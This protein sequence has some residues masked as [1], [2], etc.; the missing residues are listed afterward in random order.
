MARLSRTGNCVEPPFARARRRIIGIN[1]SANAIFTAGNSDEHQILDNQRS[2]REAVALG[3]LGGAYVPD[4]IAGL[5]VQR[6][7]MRVQRRHENFITEDGKSAVDSPATW[8]NV[9][10][11]QA[12]VLPDR[13]PGTRVQGIDAVVLPGTVHNSVHNKRRCFKFAPCHR[14]ICPLGYERCGIRRIDLIQRTE[15]MPRIVSG[16]HQPVLWLLGGVEQPLESHLPI[17]LRCAEAQR[18]CKRHNKRQC[19]SERSEESAFAFSTQ[20]HNFHC[21]PPFSLAASRNAMRSFKSFSGRLLASYAG[22]NDS[23]VFSKDRS[24][25]F[26]NECSSSRVS[27]ICTVKLSSLSTTPCNLDSFT[28]RK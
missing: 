8:P 1:E 15:A 11:E 24:L 6:D 25:A 9:R 22:I 14:L 28:D 2:Q 5:A 21:A 27:S 26:S 10:W 7:V 13:A 18:R 16:V 23:R 19:H 17:G 20:R 3:M 12:L 4:N